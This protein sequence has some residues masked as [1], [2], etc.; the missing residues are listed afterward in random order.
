MIAPSNV[1][2]F[3]ASTASK[4]RGTKVTGMNLLMW[5]EALAIAGIRQNGENRL[6]A[7]SINTRKT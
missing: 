2:Q 7:K 3:S 5:M 6:F 4:R 1:T